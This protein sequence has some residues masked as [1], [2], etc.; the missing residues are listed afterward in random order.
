M[1]LKKNP[2]ENSQEIHRGTCT[3]L[4]VRLLSLKNASDSF[5]EIF[6]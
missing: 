4:A 6:W 3:K 1:P 2:A 5:V